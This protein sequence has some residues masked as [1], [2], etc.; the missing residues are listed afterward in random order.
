MS[1]NT[2]LA[3]ALRLARE[4][5]RH[6]EAGE[7]P[8]AYD[9]IKAAD[10]AL[11]AHDAE[12]A[13]KAVPAGFV[14]VPVAMTPEMRTALL[15]YAGPGYVDEE[16]L[17]RV[18][19][20]ILAAAPTPPAPEAQQAAGQELPSLPYPQLDSI[21]A[22]TEPGYT[23]DQMRA[24]ARAAL[25]QRREPL[26][27]EQIAEGRYRTWA[28]EPDDAPEAWAFLR[29]ARWAESALAV[30]WGVKLAAT[31]GKEPGNV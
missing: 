29:G 15:D 31:T 25:A 5:F 22:F 8:Q 2:K 24:Y 27:D 9:V 12:Q 21:P 18:W 4:W 10:E 13:A 7:G 26:T 3:E 30:R 11:A 28:A 20:A 19:S 23:A 1:T 6:E 14:L 17:P 16:C